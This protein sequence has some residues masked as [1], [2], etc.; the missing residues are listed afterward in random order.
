MDIPS[1]DNI[2]MITMST[3]GNAADFGDLTTSNSVRMGGLIL[4]E[5]LRWVELLLELTIDYYVIATLG[6]AQDF[7]D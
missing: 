5:D 3:L 4:F 7:G 1:T 2:D 6:N